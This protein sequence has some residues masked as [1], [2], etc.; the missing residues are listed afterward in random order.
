MLD[1]ISN[2]LRYLNKAPKLPKNTPKQSKLQKTGNLTC[3]ESSKPTQNNEKQ[4]KHIQDQQ[5]NTK[6]PENNG[7]NDKNNYPKLCPH[8]K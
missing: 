3:G 2:L 6:D 4:A 7:E 5:N 8:K 1:T